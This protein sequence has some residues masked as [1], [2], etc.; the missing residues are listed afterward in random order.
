MAFKPLPDQKPPQGGFSYLA[1]VFG[2][3]IW[4]LCC[5]RAAFLSCSMKSDLKV[6]LSLVWRAG[7]Q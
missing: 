6:A 1:L 5:W 7:V 2:S 4:L 3:C